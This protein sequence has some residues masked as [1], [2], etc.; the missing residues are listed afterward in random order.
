MTIEIKIEGFELKYEDEYSS[1]EAHVVENLL[2]LLHGVL[3]TK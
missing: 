3:N 1:L 2:K